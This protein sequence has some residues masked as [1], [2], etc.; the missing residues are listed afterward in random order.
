MNK[1]FAI[2][3]IVLTIATFILG[4]V[5]HGLL[6]GSHY[7]ELVP[8]LFRAPEDSHKVF[9]FMILAD[10]LIGFGLTWIYRKGREA[11]KSP[12][13]QGARFGLAI[14]AMSVIPR[15]LVYYTVQPTPGILVIKQIIF[16]TLAMVILGILA[17]FLNQQT[18]LS[19]P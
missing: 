9:H 10:V 13:G 8:D 19:E 2:S 15:Y 4:F 5:V 14:A 3:W 1:R 6:L 7:S 17:A 12:I 18:R 11:G 16:D